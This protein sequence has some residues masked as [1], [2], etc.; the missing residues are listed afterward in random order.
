VELDELL[1]AVRSDRIEFVTM[2]P[3]GATTVTLERRVVLTGPPEVTDLATIGD[4]RI[5]DALV[6]LLGDPARAW[7][8]EVVLAAVTQREEK[9]V[10]TF[11]G[12]PEAWWDAVGRGAHER[13]RAWLDQH[14]DRLVWDADEGV[15]VERVDP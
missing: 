12:Q 8:A 5:L 13:W 9:L 1:A 10:D 6:D 15:F 3:P 7:A 4:I 11:A 14:R 2:R